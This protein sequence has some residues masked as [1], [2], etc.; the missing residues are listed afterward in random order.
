MVARVRALVAKLE[1][2][3]IISHD[4]TRGNLREA[5]LKDFL[6]QCLNPNFQ[7][8][9]GFVTDAYGT[10]I[11]P[12]LDIIVLDGNVSPAIELGLSISIVTIESF[13]LAIE[14]KST[15]KT[16]DL[17]QIRRQVDSLTSLVEIGFSENGISAGQ[18]PG[19]PLCVFAYESQV[20]IGTLQKWLEENESLC[21]ICVPGKF[22]MFG[23]DSVSTMQSTEEFDEVLFFL[24]SVNQIASDIGS[25]SKLNGV[26][27]SL[28]AYLQSRELPP[29]P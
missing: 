15:L 25:M 27:S 21:A 29:P 6:N 20:S 22:T 4:S 24:N 14:V 26:S 23:F 9:S 7:L 13:R 2:S 28:K 19:R 11:S 12:Q 1:E 10:D 16:T 5:Y 18:L 3:R 17:Q 8:R